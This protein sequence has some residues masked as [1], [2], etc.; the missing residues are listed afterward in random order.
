MN[1]FILASV[2][3]SQDHK[4]V[5]VKAYVVERSVYVL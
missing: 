3:P 4:T 5:V 2:I 1:E